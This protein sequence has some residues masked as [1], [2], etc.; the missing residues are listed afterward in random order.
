M[1]HA[2]EE[3]QRVLKPEGA[4]IDLRPA[5][6][7]R[8]LGT[9]AG[10]GWKFVGRL[11]EPLDDDHAANAAITDVVRRGLFWRESHSRFMLDR[12]MDTMVEVADFI[13]EFDERHKPVSH[14][15][16]LARLERQVAQQG[17]PRKFAVRGPMQLAVLRKNAAVQSRGRIG[18]PMILA[19]LPSSADAETLLN[20][21]S[22]AE[23]DLKDVSVVMKDVATRKKIAPD[24]GPL[25]VAVPAKLPNTLIAAG[26]TNDVAERSKEA[27]QAGKVLVAMNVDPKYKAAALEMF[28]DMSAEILQE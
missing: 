11:H 15:A 22:E 14:A 10:R 20:N 5:P 12:V 25:K 13:G 17:R 28:K 7:H 3:A 23:F 19:V 4:M 24:A 2:L 21:L 18:G 9:G 8:Q 1:V 6:A 16:L 26:H 27:V